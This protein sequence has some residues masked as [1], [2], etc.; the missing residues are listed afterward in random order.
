MVRYE[1]PNLVYDCLND[2]VVTFDDNTAWQLIKQYSEKPWEGSEKQEGSN[3][4][5]TEAHAVYE[6]VQTQ[7]PQPG[8]LAVV[9]VRIE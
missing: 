6:C 8:K 7:G 4:V 9:K 3:W 5:P 1:R 2:R